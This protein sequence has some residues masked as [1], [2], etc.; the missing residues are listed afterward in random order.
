MASAPT[1]DQLAD[2]A[3]G[4]GAGADV[5]ETQPLQRQD[6]GTVAKARVAELEQQMA[7]DR[8]QMAEMM[9]R[10][11]QMEM[12]MN[13][14][15][16]EEADDDPNIKNRLANHEW[17]RVPA[18]AEEADAIPEQGF[19]RW[20]ST[21]EDEE[22][23]RRVNRLRSLARVRGLLPPDTFG[24]GEW[25][26][27]IV[28]GDGNTGK[29][30]V[31]NRFAQFDFTPASDG[32]CTKRPVRLEL[33]PL[34]VDNRNAFWKK[35]LAAICTV[36]DY[37][38]GNHPNHED[39]AKRTPR[40]GPDG[41]LFE[42]RK[43]HESGDSDAFRTRIEEL[44]AATPNLHRFP[45]AAA[46]VAVVR[47]RRPEDLDTTE[48]DIGGKPTPLGS[49]FTHKT[50]VA[51]IHNSE[52]LMDELVIRVE[53]DHMIYFDL[54][55]LPGV[56]NGSPVVKDLVRK[57]FHKDRL[58]HTF[59]L[60]FQDSKGDTSLKISV[61]LGEVEA[62]LK[63]K[64]GNN[65][66]DKQQWMHTNCL[67]VLT[68]VD[69]LLE[70]DPNHN[71]TE[72]DRKF[73]ER[74][75]SWIHAELTPA[76]MLKPEWVAVLNP[77][78]EEQENGM[79]FIDAATKERW[80]FDCLYVDDDGAAYSETRARCG[81]ENLRS[82]LIAKFEQLV[83]RNVGAISHKVFTYVN[84]VEDLLSDDSYG[85]GWTWQEEEC[86]DPS[87]ILDVIQTSLKNSLALAIRNSECGGQPKTAL[88]KYKDKFENCRKKLESGSGGA[89]VKS[90]ALM[91]PISEIQ[92]NFLTGLRESQELRKFS[93]FPTLSAAIQ[94]AMEALLERAHQC[95]DSTRK[96]VARECD[97]WTAY[98]DTDATAGLLHAMKMELGQALLLIQQL[99]EQPQRDIGTIPARCLD[100]E[101]FDGVQD[102]LTDQTRLHTVLLKKVGGAFPFTLDSQ[103]VLETVEPGNAELLRMATHGMRPSEI[104]GGCTTWREGE[105]LEGFRLQLVQG[106]S[107]LARMQ[108]DSCDATAAMSQLTHELSDGQTASF[109]FVESMHLIGLRS[110]SAG[111]ASLE[112]GEGWL[113]PQQLSNPYRELR[114]GFCQA[115]RAA[116][117]LRL[118]FPEES[119]GE[120]RAKFDAKV[121][122]NRQL[123]RLGPEHERFEEWKGQKPERAENAAKVRA[124]LAGDAPLSA[125]DAEQATATLPVG[126][127]LPGFCCTPDC[128]QPHDAACK[129]CEHTVCCRD[130]LAQ[131]R[132]QRKGCP[133]CGVP[134]H[135]V[136]LCYDQSDRHTEHVEEGT[137][138]AAVLAGLVARHD[139]ER[140][141]DLAT[142]ER[143]LT[144]LPSTSVQSLGAS[145]P[146]EPISDRRRSIELSHDDRNHPMLANADPPAPVGARE[147]VGGRGASASRG[148]AVGLVRGA[149]PTVDRP[150]STH[151]E[152]EPELG[153]TSWQRVSEAPA[154]AVSPTTSSRTPN[155]ASTSRSR[156]TRRRG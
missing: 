149:P 114:N 125:D 107:I 152:P 98:G 67:G 66:G 129:P 69:K 2:D 61:V 35:K 46:G 70:T 52:F 43:Q 31:L 79:D 137:P 128:C 38:D 49:L 37:R 10:M 97:E 126:P 64:F 3:L 22:S 40:N 21:N 136:Y 74:L 139:C 8:R 112:P 33:R 102:Y 133:V 44:S 51:A 147:T 16:Q 91:E 108:R 104:S 78:P 92:T 118:V 130:C 99:L 4:G 26:Q 11:K 89:E 156:R 41:E 17:T 42:I 124:V 82:R 143:V 94:K 20:Y 96:K 111:A 135:E 122:G 71:P 32:T 13:A 120:A 153:G 119:R 123:I 55:D 148:T 113:L 27:V 106:R 36:R 50:D 115:R 145:Q 132:A 75:K 146:A 127:R 84:S 131:L 144:G 57:Y 117:L 12:E 72:Y 53:A 151:H 6:S 138:P 73:R 48:V 103:G 110:Q 19:L 134:I 109:A 93:R 54:I 76:H 60:L 81:I 28:C 23:S 154:T 100:P 86:G 68:K 155:T 150:R 5:I 29:S 63:E 24:E 95:S 34:K 77:N 25:P 1:Q 105:G 39:P 85:Y 45:G 140:S 9:R 14:A 101:V 47:G 65:Q 59:M 87:T 30:T 56:E 15:R 142:R 90:R 88:E 80:F 116:E 141:S 62:L 58:D 83:A 7:E 18:T 121:G